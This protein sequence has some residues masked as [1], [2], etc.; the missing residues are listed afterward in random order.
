MQTDLT[1]GGFSDDDDVPWTPPDLAPELVRKLS[2]GR[3]NAL[4]GRYL[5]AEHDD[6]DELLRRIDEIRER[7]LNEI[8]SVVEKSD[9][10]SELTW[11]D[12]QGPHVRRDTRRSGSARRR[13]QQHHAGPVWVASA[14]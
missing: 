8:G 9:R 12:V 2:T 6:V 11:R 10:P 5:H 3:Y 14:S 7:D 1:A 4:A 13:R